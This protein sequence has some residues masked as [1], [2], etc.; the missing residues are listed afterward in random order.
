MKKNV[1][2]IVL[3][4]IAAASVESTIFFHNQTDKLNYQKKVLC[5]SLGKVRAENDS[6][7]SLNNQTDNVSEGRKYVK[8]DTHIT[9]YRALQKND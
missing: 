3:A 4:V 7:R 8:L 2:I 1:A 5:K 9:C 6:L